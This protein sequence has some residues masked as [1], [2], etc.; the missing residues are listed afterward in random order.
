MQRDIPP[1]FGFYQRR[2]TKSSLRIIG[3]RDS[4]DMDMRFGL[5]I[6]LLGQIILRMR[7]TVPD[8]ISEKRRA[9]TRSCMRMICTPLNGLGH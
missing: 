1:S 4:Y 3:T 6:R 9:H 5:F 8:L 2:K 7:L